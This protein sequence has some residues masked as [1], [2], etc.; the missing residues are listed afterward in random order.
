MTL[1]SRLSALQQQAGTRIA[2]AP[3]AEPRATNSIHRRLAHLRPERLYGLPVP[4]FDKMSAEELAR[5]VNG[6]FVAEGLIKIEHEV[7][8]SGRIGNIELSELK[9]IPLLPG[10]TKPIPGIYIDTETTGLAGGSG[11]LAFLI[12]VAVIHEESIRLTQLLITSFAAE[13]ALLAE[14]EKLLP[15][16][17]RLV[18][19]NGKSYDLPLLL[20]RFRMRGLT[21]SF[22]E[23]NHLDLLHPVRRLF[24]KRWEDCRLATVEKN[25]LGFH[26]TDDL[27]GAEA[28]EAWFTF[29]RAGYGKKLVKVVEHNRQDILSLA[30]A[31]A[32]LAQAVADPVSHNPDHYG[33][34]RWLSEVN[35]QNAVAL[36]RSA[37]ETLCD[38]SRRLLAHLLRRDGNWDE[39]VPIWEGLAQQGCVDS[40]ERLAKYHEHVSKDLETAWR[41]SERLPGSRAD[42]H[43]RNRLREK[44]TKNKPT[45]QSNVSQSKG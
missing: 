27:P 4:S 29:L 3:Q 45:F 25:L 6:D 10:E 31:H 41:Y 13:P 35:E 20:T 33:L 1:K 2:T 26:R 37:M 39:A 8:L 17:H 24:A 38:D 18:S 22:A 12:G 28:P 34:A 7:P 19:Y 14:V 36:L 40:I 9:E 15:P 42:N 30:A 11:T 5:A 32:M 23:R 16:G 43:R 44:L 21:P